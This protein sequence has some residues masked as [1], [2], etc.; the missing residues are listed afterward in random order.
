MISARVLQDRKPETLRASGLGNTTSCFS[1]LLRGRGLNTSR[2]ST[3]LGKVSLTTLKDKVSASYALDEK[4]KRVGCIHF[5]LA[6]ASFSLFSSLYAT[7]SF[8]EQF[9]SKTL[10]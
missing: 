10:T 2:K 5:W 6:Q 1:S 8:L 7:S 4:M 9:P 3:N